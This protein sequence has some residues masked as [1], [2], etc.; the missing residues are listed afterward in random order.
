MAFYFP[1][2]ER[3]WE[4]SCKMQMT[5]LASF[6]YNKINMYGHEFKIYIY[7][8]KAV[9]LYVVYRALYIKFL[10]EFAA[11]KTIWL[12]SN[13]L[14]NQRAQGKIKRRVIVLNFC[15]SPTLTEES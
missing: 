5:V 2:N 14:A 6:P 10:N 15:N 13:L 3:H 11:L 4:A 1:Q 7:I 9:C 12:A 8:K